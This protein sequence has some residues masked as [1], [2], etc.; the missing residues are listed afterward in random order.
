MFRR[1]RSK[2]FTVNGRGTFV[3]LCKYSGK[4]IGISVS[5]K[6]GDFLYGFSRFSKEL[7]GVGQT[8]LIQILYHSEAKLPSE[9]RRNIVGRVTEMFG[10]LREG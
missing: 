6:L 3:F 1:D 10:K 4:I 7:T 2:F 9:G 5:G 8:Y